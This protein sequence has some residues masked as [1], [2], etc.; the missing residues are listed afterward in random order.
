M[1]AGKM[2]VN[3]RFGTKVAVLAGD[4]LFAQSSWYLANLDNLEVC[5]PAAVC[6]LPHYYA[7]PLWQSLCS[8]F[9][10]EACQDRIAVST[11]PF[12]FLW[13]PAIGHGLGS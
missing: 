11:S 13:H 9:Q 8:L 12:M 10:V 4:F 7:H 5:C 1:R 3:S 6:L 2:T